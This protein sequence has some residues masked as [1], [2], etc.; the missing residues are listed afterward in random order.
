MRG[1]AASSGPRDRR[2]KPPGQPAGWLVGVVCV[3]AL[4]AVWATFMSPNAPRRLGRAARI[5]LG[6]ALVVTVAA[7]LAATG[8][9]TFAWLLGVAGVI[10]TTVAQAI[11]PP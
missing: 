10:V 1:P 5:V 11:A 3:A 7:A 2:L 8:A 4:V 9:T 6:D